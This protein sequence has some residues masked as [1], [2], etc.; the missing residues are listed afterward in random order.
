MERLKTYLI[1]SLL[2]AGLGFSANIAC[3]YRIVIDP[4][5]VAA[6][7][8][9]TGTQKLIEDQH[10]KRL[11]SIAAK[12]KKIE[13]FTATMATIAE[14]YQISMQNIK[15]FGSESKYYISIG[16]NAY[17]IVTRI[18]RITKTIIKAKVPGQASCLAEMTQIYNQTQ[19]LV[20]DFVN[21]V[22]NAKV[23]SP[24][25]N[26]K[27]EKKGDGYNLLDR[28]DRLAVAIKIDADLRI[29]RYKVEW[30][31][32][33]ANCATWDDMFRTIDPDG[34][35][36]YMSGKNRVEFIISQWNGL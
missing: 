1:L 20:S 33:L 31:E 2:M 21:I 30:L 26:G 4:K 13:Q 5:T 19:Q 36:N 12:Q 9:N 8:Q 7:I 6:V 18:P 32:M 29:L 35:I 15:G 28:Y 17:E 25:K 27:T 22:N 34:W 11:D 14:V 10:N 3:G 24:L 16:L 23:E